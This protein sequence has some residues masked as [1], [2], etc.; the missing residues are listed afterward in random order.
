M[1]IEFQII[2]PKP[3]GRQQAMKV[4]MRDGMQVRQ[5]QLSIGLEDDPVEVIPP[6][7]EALW[8]TADAVTDGL[9]AW[10]AF[11][12]RQSNDLLNQTI[13]AVFATMQAG[14]NMGAMLQAGKAVLLIDPLQ[15]MFFG[16]LSQA[17]SQASEAERLEFITLAL[18]VAYGKL[19]QR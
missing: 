3:L 9:R 1:A 8:E 14:G 6:Q 11:L 2:D 15:G 19:G 7:L 5:A 13:F 17:M 10:F 4:L 12:Q 18:T 16:A